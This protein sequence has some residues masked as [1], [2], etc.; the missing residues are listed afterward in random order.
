MG[1]GGAAVEWLSWFI[2]GRGRSGH[3]EAL[4]AVYELVEEGVR[5]A[6]HDFEPCDWDPLKLNLHAKG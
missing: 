2:G 1:L 6:G 3:S 5:Y 4:A